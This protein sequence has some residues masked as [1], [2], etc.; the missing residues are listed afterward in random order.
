MCLGPNSPRY[1]MEHQERNE[2]DPLWTEDEVAE[3]LRVSP[4]T[5]RKWVKQDR[6]P[7][8][9]AGSLNRFRKSEIAEWS[10]AHRDE[11]ESA[12]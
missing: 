4:A 11:A 3:Y 8:V 12:A 2:L 6:I 10:A 9:K 1:I 5:V 7:F